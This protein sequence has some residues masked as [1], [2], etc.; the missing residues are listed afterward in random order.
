MM[1]DGEK[2]SCRNAGFNVA[3]IQ[4]RSASEWV[5]T[6][7]RSD[8]TTHSALADFERVDPLAGASSWYFLARIAKIAFAAQHQNLRFELVW[9]DV[10]SLAM[11][12]ARM[13]LTQV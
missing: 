1:A 5:I 3:P 11:R 9:I 6:R 7:F 8:F 10:S 12:N 4:A 2:G 13:Y